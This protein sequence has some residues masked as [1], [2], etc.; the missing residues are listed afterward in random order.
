MAKI[1]RKTKKKLFS[2]L[3]RT[4]NP[5]IRKDLYGNEIDF[6]QYGE[7]KENGWFIIENEIKHWSQICTNSD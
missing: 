2:A 5:F 7:E 4:E 3:A 6:N 1:N